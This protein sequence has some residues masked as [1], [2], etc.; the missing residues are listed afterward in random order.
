M[1]AAAIQYI[2][3]TMPFSQDERMRIQVKIME[4]KALAGL[5]GDDA[6]AKATWDAILAWWESML[7]S[8]L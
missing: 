2:G 4:C 3:A 8:H 7:E 1:I 5:N 6:V